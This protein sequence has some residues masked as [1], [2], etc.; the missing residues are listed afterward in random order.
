MTLT[1]PFS[2]T[3]KPRNTDPDS[4]ILVARRAHSTNSHR[5]MRAW[6]FFFCNK[7]QISRQMFCE[8][9][10]CITVCY[11]F[12]SANARNSLHSQFAM[13]G[14]VSITLRITAWIQSQKSTVSHYLCIK[15][16]ING[17]GA[18]RVRKH[19]AGRASQL[20]YPPRTYGAHP[21]VAE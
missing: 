8:Y 9:Y 14:T 13:A 4:S 11:Q 1:H 3:K 20:L 15:T 5:Q 18:Q 17:A 19:S 6:I 2:V 10:H 12:T 16:R 21:T 7:G